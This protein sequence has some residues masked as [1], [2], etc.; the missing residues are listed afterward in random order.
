MAM[1]LTYHVKKNK[2]IPI[3]LTILIGTCLTI[4]SIL[5]GGVDTQAVPLQ[6]EGNILNALLNALF[7]FIPGIV[8]G[9]FIF[10]LIKTDRENVL[11]KLIFG[12]FLFTSTLIMF[13][14]LYDVLYILQADILFIFLIIPISIVF[15]V[16]VSKALFSEDLIKKNVA[17]LLLG[18]FLGG[19]L[20]IYMPTWTTVI[21]L[22]L[23]SVYDIWAVKRGTIK[24]IFDYY[25]E[26]D[27]KD[28]I[29]ED[30]I[31]K[32]PKNLEFEIGIGDLVFY[33]MFASH[34]FYLVFGTSRL[35]GLLNK[36][37]SI[38]LLVGFISS[39]IPFIL[40]LIGI[41]IGSYLTFKLLIKEKMLPGLPISIGLGITIFLI[42]TLIY[43]II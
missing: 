21:M 42:C 17:I 38:N 16:L 3:I 2:Y 13:L 15:G 29:V 37:Y 23:Y 20:G 25:D 43:F 27:A 33:T 39:I 40:V 6:E 14:V 41:I 30:D 9:I 7:F 22:S 32:D 28:S 35:F 18:S 8:G 24:K 11:E 5:S 4:I 26:K 31:S 36:F 19:F 1:E 12:I 34:V 10:H